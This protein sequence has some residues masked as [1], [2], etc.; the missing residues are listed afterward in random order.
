MNIN[1]NKGESLWENLGLDSKFMDDLDDKFNKAVFRAMQVEYKTEIVEHI[2]ENFSY[3]E[4]VIIAAKYVDEVC[5]K[6]LRN[7]SI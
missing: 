3:N 7:E 4:L 1:N 2:L 5:I 6:Y